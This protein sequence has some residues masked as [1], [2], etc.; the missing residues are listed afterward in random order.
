M[1]GEPVSGVS[2]ITD[3]T[4][5]VF[6]IGSETQKVLSIPLIGVLVIRGTYHMMGW[7]SGAPAAA[8]GSRS[9]SW[10]VDAG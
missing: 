4:S 2:P 8:A 1:D 7:S 3:S 6:S 10:G 9:T 5:F